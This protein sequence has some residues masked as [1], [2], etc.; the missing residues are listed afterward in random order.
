MKE[1][2]KLSRERA[3]DYVMEHHVCERD[4]AEFRVMLARGEVTIYNYAKNPKVSFEDAV[5]FY[6]RE[7]GFRRVDAERYVKRIRGETPGDWVETR[8]DGTQIVHTV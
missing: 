3:I 7:A 5:E 1:L 6:I 4:E 2:V 8:P